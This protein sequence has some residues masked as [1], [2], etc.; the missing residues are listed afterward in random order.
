MKRSFIILITVI[1]LIGFVNVEALAENNTLENLIESRENEKRQQ[2]EGTTGM[3]ERQRKNSEFIKGMNEA[4]DLSADIQSAKVVTQGAHKAVSFLVQ[5]LFYLIVILMTLRIALDLMYISI[6]F[7]RKWLGGGQSG[8]PTTGGFG[9]GF[10][11][12]MA[13]HSL[14]GFGS[15][16]GFQSG[17]GSMGSTGGSQ[18]VSNAALNAVASEKAV[19]PNGKPVGPFRIYVKDMI[20]MLIMVPILIML[21]IT[22]VLTDLGF[23]IG[24]LLVDNIQSLKGMI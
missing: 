5:V 20:V 12:G 21:A 7:S 18:L 17:G 3:T 15:S 1:C 4:A 16:G 23:L 2:S 24:Q 10:G 22:G 9:G 8:R 6:P 11:G 19:G 13:G 14:P